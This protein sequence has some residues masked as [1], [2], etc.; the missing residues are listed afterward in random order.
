[1]ICVISTRGYRPWIHCRSV[2]GPVAT[3]W[4]F[5]R[6]TK[7]YWLIAQYVEATK[8]SLPTSL[9]LTSS[10]IETKSTASRPIASAFVAQVHETSSPALLRVLYVSLRPSP[11]TLAAASHPPSSLTNLGV[12]KRETEDGEIVEVDPIRAKRALVEVVEVVDVR[13]TADAAA[14]GSSIA[15]PPTPVTSPNPSVASPNLS[16]ASPRMAT[17]S[18][19]FR[20]PWD[21][22]DTGS[23]GLAVHMNFLSFASADHLVTAHPSFVTAKAPASDCTN[24]PS[25][26]NRAIYHSKVSDRPTSCGTCRARSQP[27]AWSQGNHASPTVAHIRN[28]NPAGRPKRTNGR[29]MSEHTGL[30]ATI[31]KCVNRIKISNKSTSASDPQAI[32]GRASCA[33]TS[34]D[35]GASNQGNRRVMGL[36]DEMKR[37]D[38]REREVV[39]LISDADEDDA[40]VSGRTARTPPRMSRPMETPPTRPVVVP[41]RPQPS[42]PPRKA[43]PAHRQH[44][45]AK[46]HCGSVR[47]GDNNEYTAKAEAIAAR[48]ARDTMGG[49]EL[50]RA[51][52][53]GCGDVRHGD[54]L[55][56]ET[57][58]PVERDDGASEHVGSVLDQME[59]GLRVELGNRLGEPQMDFDSLTSLLDMLGSHGIPYSEASAEVDLANVGLDF[60]W[61]D[62]MSQGGQGIGMQGLMGGDEGQGQMAGMEFGTNVVETARGEVDGQTGAMSEE[63]LAQLLAAFG[64]S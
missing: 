44:E 53:P 63:D 50:R 10:T 32:S 13:P 45:R 24:G 39:D 64:S 22:T 9:P 20:V 15:S 26:M 33:K 56:G 58:R 43:H 52:G 51:S 59:L 16:F 40:L 23:N 4:W 19:A 6:R 7:G 29:E 25:T 38:K 3:C 36:K 12:R 14:S 47:G 42:T 35:D 1:M 57:I 37:E 21:H 49:S 60:S 46:V 54:E 18:P 27:P 62:S 61:V 48:R 2:S 8:A 55:W 28:S 11:A 5:S 34:D 41:L 30:G 17:S 31:G